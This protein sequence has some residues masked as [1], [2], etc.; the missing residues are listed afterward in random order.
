MS[1]I[2][3]A[4]TAVAALCGLMGNA[5]ALP[6]IWHYTGTINPAI[7]NPFNFPVPVGETVEITITFD[8]PLVDT[9]SLDGASDY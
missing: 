7:R 8:G 9:N 5:F 1:K 2:L 3:T 4:L 6:T